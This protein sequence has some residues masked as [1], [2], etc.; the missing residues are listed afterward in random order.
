VEALLSASR[1]E[2]RAGREGAALAW[3]EHAI[4]LAEGA[5][6]RRP[7]FAALAALGA[8]EVA[9]FDDEAAARVFQ[10]CLALAESEGERRC[11]AAACLALGRIAGRRENLQGAV[12]WFL[13]GLDHAVGDNV[14]TGRLH[15]AMSSVLAER[16]ELAAAAERLER[17]ESLLSDGADPE[18]GAGLVEAAVS[19]A[20]LAIHSGRPDD[21][22]MHYHEAL[23]HAMRDAGD[24]RAGLRVRIALTRFLLHAGRLA[25]AEDEA[26]RAEEQAVLHG[27]TRKLALLY[28]IVGEI[29]RRQRD[30]SAITFFEEAIELS[31]P[32]SPTPTP[33][34]EAEA[35]AAYARFRRDFGELDDA[36]AY[37]ERSRALLVALGDSAAATRLDAEVAEVAELA[38]L[39]G[40]GSRT[41]PDPTRAVSD[42]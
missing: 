30:E 5:R 11:A 6:D 25:D 14:S 31:R 20:Q 37:L 40:G 26:R 1:L 15:L 29:R 41:P 19:R 21:A 13:R 12:S 2:D 3:I 42:G 33:R 35:Y 17:A 9:T 16:G 27:R 36:R 7:E 23:D 10:R 39:P 18:R 38:A 28:V 4:R 34:I 8:H 24:P 22:V 32:A